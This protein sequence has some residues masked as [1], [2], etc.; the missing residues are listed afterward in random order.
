MK[1]QQKSKNKRYGI[2]EKCNK[3]FA[4]TM[5]ENNGISVF[6]KEFWRPS[7]CENCRKK[8]KNK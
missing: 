7:L 6:I 3:V 8:Q 5:T 2:C 4:T 1:V